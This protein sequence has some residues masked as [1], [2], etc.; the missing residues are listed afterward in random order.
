MSL[1]T[2][3][4]SYSTV[5][6]VLITRPAIF[7]HCLRS[8]YTS[9][10]RKMRRPQR[11]INLVLR[12]CAPFGKGWPATARNRTI[13]TERMIRQSTRILEHVICNKLRGVLCINFETGV[14]VFHLKIKATRVIKLHARACS[15]FAFSQIVNLYR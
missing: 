6:Y 9:L 1:I 13:R 2:S 8:R 15:S 3:N 11:L 7:D 14:Q 4:Y 5:S 10:A 12:C